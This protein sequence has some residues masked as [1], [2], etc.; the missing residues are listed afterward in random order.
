MAIQESQRV[1]GIQYEQSK[2]HQ[3][4]FFI[5]GRNE[6]HLARALEE[7]LKGRAHVKVSET[8][9]LYQETVV[10][11]K[12]CLIESISKRNMICASGKPLGKAL[13]KDLERID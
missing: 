13:V 8:Y 1:N 6:D 11:S 4:Q 9:V 3:Y 2:D 12:A 5:I 10:S 7:I